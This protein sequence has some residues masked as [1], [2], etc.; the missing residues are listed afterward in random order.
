MESIVKQRLVGA[1]VLVAL[2]VIFIPMLLDGGQ[3]SEL[4]ASRSNI[5]PRPGFHFEPLDLPPP[6]PEPLEP[7]AAVVE[8]AEVP[9]V[10]LGPVAEEVR[11]EPTEAVEAPS[12]A[13]EAWAVQVGSFS[14][15]KNALALRDKLRSAGF[16]AFVEQ[17]TN[18]GQPV[19]R[20]RIG[21]EA[22]RSR[23]ESLKA[24]VTKAFDKL[25]ALVMNHP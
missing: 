16:A 15:E 25:P 6:A 4:A 2:A 14:S 5:P 24:R 23:A 1:I 9:P 11:A 10:A 17:V 3:P 12:T 13:V 8:E 7:R 20:V 18:A 19:F 22:T 21:P